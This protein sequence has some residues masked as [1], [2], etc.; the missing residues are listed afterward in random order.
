MCQLILP[1][2]L[3]KVID[4]RR[5]IT[6]TFLSKVTFAQISNIFKTGQKRATFKARTKLIF[7]SFM[8]D[9]YLFRR[10]ARNVVAKVFVLIHPWQI[11]ILSL[12]IFVYV[13]CFSGQIFHAWLVLLCTLF[14]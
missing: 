12:Q 2:P 9:L 3:A 7:I 5:K 14:N 11:N 1:F 6:K 8:T 4:E 13:T 10:K